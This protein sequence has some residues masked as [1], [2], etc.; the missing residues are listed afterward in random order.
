MIPT[1]T[2]TRT[3]ST[4]TIT[5]FWLALLAIPAGSGCLQFETADPSA[6][7]PADAIRIAALTDRTGTSATLSYSAAIQLA[8]KQMKEGLENSTQRDIQFAL[9]LRDTASKSDQAARQAREAVLG[10]GARALITE[11]SADTIAVNALNYAENLGVPV[12]CFACSSS[13]INNPTAVDPDP[14]RQ[15]A[16]RDER[17]YLH[18]LFMNS[19]YEAAVQMRVAMSHGNQGDA[20]G[21]G[22]FKVALIATDDPYGKGWESALRTKMMEMHPLSSSIEV[23]YVDPRVNDTSYNWNTDLSRLIDKRNDSTNMDDGEPDV[24]FLAL[25]PVG[26]G[27]ATK[28]YREAGH[29]IPL[30]ATTAFRRLHILR[31]LGANAE[32]V[33]GGSPRAG[34]GESGAA[35]EAAFQAEY[36]ED[37]EMLS[38]GAYDCAVT[39]MLA[40]LQAIGTSSDPARATPEAIRQGLDRINDP[41]GVWVG[42]GADEFAKA[43]DVIKAGRTINYQGATGET[44]FDANGDTHPIMVHYRVENNRFRELETY[45]CSEAN[46][47]CISAQP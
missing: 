46:P 8:F 9:L 12:N 17:N 24:V 33:E 2:A 13:F 14:L 47:L 26:S 27:A 35:F 19:I 22:W 18:R 5:T 25:L 45:A 43:A 21:D 10:Q 4:A 32:G 3:T 38:A 29:D 40:A 28:A 23:L 30:Q 15:A 6:Q 31:A 39:H 37:P 36:G 44:T 34:A 7:I 1:R 20:N 42:V 11:I 16:E 41:A